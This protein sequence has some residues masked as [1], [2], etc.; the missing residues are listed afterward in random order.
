MEL[1]SEGSAWVQSLHRF[2]DD[3]DIEL[4]LRDSDFEGLTGSRVEVKTLRGQCGL[5]APMLS[6]EQN[7]P[8]A[9]DL[10]SQEWTPKAM[11][12]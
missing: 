1:P 9:W 6:L 7:T 12:V 5:N 4:V 3:T 8:D 10:K 2:W 11:V